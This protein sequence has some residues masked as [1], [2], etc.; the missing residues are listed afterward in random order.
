MSLTFSVVTLGCKTN[1]FESISMEEK[2]VAAGYRSV[3]YEDGADLVVV[4]T[5][6][7]TTATDSQSRNLIRR[8]RRMNPDCRVIVTGCYAQ[9]DPEAIRSIPG[10]SVVLGN[11]DKKD[12]VKYLEIDPV[13]PLIEVSD[14]QK[15]IDAVPH[16][17]SS[18]AER[19]RAFVQIQNGCNAYCSYC[20]IPYARGRSRSASPDQVLEQVRRLVA[21]GYPEIVLT[22]IHIGAYGIDLQPAS[23]LVEL[24]RRIEAETMV[25][26][27]RLGSI[28][29]NEIGDSLIELLAGSDIVCPHL[30]VPLQA[31]DDDVLNR[32][33]RHYSVDDFSRLIDKVHRQLPDVAF[34]FDVITGFP[35]ET[36][37]EFANTVRLIESL[38]AA[39]L[40]V[41]P[42]SRRPGTP[43]ADMAGQ[44]PGDVARQRATILRQLGQ[45][46][47]RLFAER[48]IGQK[49]E[50]V[51]EGGGAKEG[52]YK[53]L[54]RHYLPVRFKG[55]S[56][57]V[58]RLAQVKMMAWAEDHL[59]GE[60][61]P[62]T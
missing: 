45:K 32:M 38:P 40:H 7:V 19:S 29:P 58:G 26:R 11:D 18:F 1:Q 24:I 12:L 21:N 39:F 43:A 9:V 61:L 20:I 28:E 50:V 42:F 48:F 49:L 16:E 5:C 55:S 31:G 8:A 13:E 2:L 47:Q 57:N 25:H 59:L 27:L 30:H 14:I 4:N 51:V 17:I 36:E 22:G 3:S 44:V 60:L 54:T 34:G 33:N 35:G 41:F 53:G 10:V 6:T 62:D 37:M 23:S 15:V 46:K 52:L 56:R